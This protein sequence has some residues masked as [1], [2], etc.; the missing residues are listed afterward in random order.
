MLLQIM[1]PNVFGGADLLFQLF[2]IHTSHRAKVFSHVSAQ[3]WG[4]EA[5]VLSFS[6]SSVLPQNKLPFPKLLL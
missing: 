6:C 1:F 5:T 3:Q 4:W 2:Q